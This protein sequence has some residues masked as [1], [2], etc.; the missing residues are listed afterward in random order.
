MGKNY[1]LK[2]LRVGLGLRQLD[3]AIETKGVIDNFKMSRIE[4]GKYQPNEE[5]ISLL[6]ATLKVTTD[7]LEE[8]IN[9][10]STN[11]I[12]KQRTIDRDS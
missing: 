7:K 12:S 9:G 8:I 5:E 10:N 11:T 1:K 4:S 2:S 6:A 3:I